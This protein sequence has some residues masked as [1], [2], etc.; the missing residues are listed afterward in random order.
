MKQR[1]GMIVFSCLVSVAVLVGCQSMLG[2]AG[3]DKVLRLG[4]IPHENREEMEDKYEELVNYLETELNVRVKIYVASDYDGV[5]EAMRERK[6]DFA[7]FGPLSYLKAEKEVGAVP[8]VAEHFEDQGN[9]YRSLIIT[10][11]DSGLTSLQALKGKSFAFVD[12]GSTS[13][14]LMQ[15]A[16]LKRMH[17]DPARFFGQVTY[18]GG[19]NAV[20]RMVYG[21]QVDAGAMDDITYRKLVNE[22]KINPNE[23]R[24]LWRSS[25][26]PGAPIAVHPQLDAELK[27]K[28]A[29]ALTL[30][31]DKEPEALEALG[32]SSYVR[33]DRDYYKPVRDAM[34]MVNLQ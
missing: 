26:I 1:L 4:V 20:G 16:H 12:P 14:Y 6:V 30:A 13:G 11:K 18:A 7:M 21:K 2:V 23:M 19:H 24:I 31:D 32:V 9:E 10:R 33:T 5:V 34:Q 25:L 15:T 28:L 27:E 22:G 3:S 8:I 29:E 17:I